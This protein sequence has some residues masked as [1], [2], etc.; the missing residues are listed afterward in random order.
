[1]ENKKGNFLKAKFVLSVIAVIASLAAQP[2]AAKP[3]AVS[4][5]E[6]DKLLAS[7]Q[8]RDPATGLIW[9]RCSLGQKWINKT[10]QGDPVLFSY[11]SGVDNA[12]E[13][14][15]KFNEDGFADHKNWKVPTIAQLASIRYCSKGWAYEYDNGV[16]TNHVAKQRLPD[17]RI[18]NS[19]CEGEEGYV[20]LDSTTFPNTTNINQSQLMYLS[21]TFNDEA[22]AG[23]DYTYWGV[24]F[25]GGEVRDYM[26]MSALFRLVRQPK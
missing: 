26:P 15:K 11:S 22:G 3:K 17:G 7:G 9:M 12:L 23:G 21:S 24:M 16:K 2:V 4:K 5:A 20:A 8:W 6:A 14:E 25:E 13:I 19:Y 1:M 18:V 10:C